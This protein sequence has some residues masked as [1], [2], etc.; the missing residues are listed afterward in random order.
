MAHTILQVYGSIYGQ[1]S[2]VEWRVLRVAVL[3]LTLES[4]ADAFVVVFGL[5]LALVT[6][7]GCG[8]GLIC[9][10]WCWY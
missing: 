4:V 3:G 9:K 7:V 6:G 1:C 8:D 2:G 5:L 10:E